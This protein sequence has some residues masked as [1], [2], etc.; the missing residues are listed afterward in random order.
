MV[1][2]HSEKCI[3]LESQKYENFKEI[4]LEIDNY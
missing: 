2:D 3:K 4:N 1:T